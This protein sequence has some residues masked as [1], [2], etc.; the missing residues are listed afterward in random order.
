MELSG[1]FQTPVALTQGKNPDAHWIGAWMGPK[2]GLCV[3]EKP[4]IVPNIFFSLLEF[5]PQVQ[6]RLFTLFYVHQ[7][8]H[9]GV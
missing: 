7:I 9:C 8:A 5:F 1:L 3:L 6:Q 2:A 4:R